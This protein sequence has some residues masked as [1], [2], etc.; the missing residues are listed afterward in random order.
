MTFYIA[1]FKDMEMK[2][3]DV[4]V[5]TP[6]FLGGADPK[7]AELRAASIKGSLRFWWRALYGC[8][9]LADMKKRESEIFGSTE[10][11]SSFSIQLNGIDNIKPIMKNVDKGKIFVV[12]SSKGTFRLGII[13]YLAFGIRDH[14]QGYTKEHI[15]SSAH[16]SIKLIFN[17]CF[18]DEVLESFCNFIRFG[19]LGAKSRNGFGSLHIEDLPKHTKSYQNE[20]RGFCSF[21]K[22][23]I[24]FNN[25]AE[26]LKWED[27]LSEIGL[28]YKDARLTIERKHEY[29]KRLLIAKPIVQA[30]NNDRHAKPYFLHVNK[31][32][33][34]KYQ[35][36]ILFMPYNYD[37]AKR[38]EYFDACKQMNEILAKSSGGLR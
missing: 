12:N 15:Q 4:E 3:F 30:H 34:G 37:Q 6:L 19:G 24:F 20:L 17:R 8:D 35:G 14:K 7:K 18:S 25:F 16:F 27:A 10:K 5:V 21:S 26:H 23:T 28:A 11:K 38:K 29:D 13:D 22:K 36:Q 33:N 1:R 31:L 2:E 32:S 9:D